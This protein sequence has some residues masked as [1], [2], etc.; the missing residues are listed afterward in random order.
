MPPIDLNIPFADL[1][2]S[3]DHCS[4]AWDKCT[5]EGTEGGPGAHHKLP[6]SLVVADQMQ[7]YQKLANT[8]MNWGEMRLA[9]GVVRK[10]HLENKLS[11]S[12]TTASVAAC[13][14][15]PEWAVVLMRLRQ[16]APE[17]SR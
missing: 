9:G 7:S 14:R 11:L 6:S 16:G 4:Y 12:H 17:V 1:I 8:D 2:P 13:R 15:I 10:Q 5:G 3:M